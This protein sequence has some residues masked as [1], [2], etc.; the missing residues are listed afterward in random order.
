[1]SRDVEPGFCWS[2]SSFWIA[3]RRGEIPHIPFSGLRMFKLLLILFPENVNKSTNLHT[4]N[5]MLLLLLLLLL[6]NRQGKMFLC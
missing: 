4:K 6:L 2:A 1:M 5:D 3:D